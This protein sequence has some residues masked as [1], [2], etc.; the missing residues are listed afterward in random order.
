MI[1]LTKDHLVHHIDEESSKF[2]APSAAPMFCE[3][4]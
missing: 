4:Y 1:C 2:P 3:E